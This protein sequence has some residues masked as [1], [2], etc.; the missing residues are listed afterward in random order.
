ML[1]FLS[2]LM[3]VSVMLYHYPLFILLLICLLFVPWRV[4]D[5]DELS[6]IG[7]PIFFDFVAISVH[8]YF[9]LT[10]NFKC[11]IMGFLSD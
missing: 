11:Q 9:R 2:L 3:I 4:L 5:S 6:Y 10:I 1:V 8:I 7:L